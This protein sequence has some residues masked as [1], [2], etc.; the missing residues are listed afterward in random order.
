[1][2]ELPKFSIDHVWRFQKKDREWSDMIAELLKFSIERIGVFNKEP[3]KFC[4]KIKSF[5][6]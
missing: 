1:M 6:G 5:L 3:I 4:L 2:A